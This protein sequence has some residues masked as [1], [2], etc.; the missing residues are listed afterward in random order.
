[1]LPAAV[2]PRS[3]PGGCKTSKPAFEK[4]SSQTT[5]AAMKRAKRVTDPFDNE[6]RRTGGEF[7]GDFFFPDY[8][9]SDDARRADEDSGGGFEGSDDEGRP[10]VYSVPVALMIRD[11]VTLRAAPPAEEWLRR[12]LTADAIAAANRFAGLRQDRAAFQRPVMMFLREMGYDAGLCN[13]AACESGCAGY[14]YIDVLAS[15]TAPPAIQKR[16]IVDVNFAEEFAIARP[17]EEYERLLR[18]LPPVFVGTAL[19][20]RRLLEILADAARRSLR[21]REMYLPPWRRSRYILAKWLDPHRRSVG[22]SSPSSRLVAA[23]FV[24]GDVKRRLV[25]FDAAASAVLPAAARTR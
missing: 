5:A 4:V 1:M 23:P 11:L 9:D 14:T 20:L 8:E 6:L 24:R 17:T 3:R 10:F 16:Y 22:T 15:T 21:S 12:N 13:T 25:G 7:V 2:K 18:E 19:E